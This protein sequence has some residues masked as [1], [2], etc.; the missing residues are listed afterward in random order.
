[1]LAT[2]INSLLKIQGS[3]TPWTAYVDDKYELLHMREGKDQNEEKMQ[4]VNQSNSYV[5]FFI[6]E[7]NKFASVR[8]LLPPS[9]V[10]FPCLKMTIFVEVCSTESEIE[11]LSAIPAST[12][13]CSHTE[14]SR[15][16]ARPP[17]CGKCPES[18]SWRNSSAHC[19]ENTR[20]QRN[21]YSTPQVSQVPVLLYCIVLPLLWTT[22]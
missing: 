19:Q 10:K 6:F 11:R 18:C 22:T 20:I 21:L 15:Y 12:I 8:D 16:R 2:K 14:V 4:K 7:L 9:P 17:C 13:S 1:M 3:C 5:C